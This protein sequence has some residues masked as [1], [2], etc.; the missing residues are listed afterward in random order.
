MPGEQDRERDREARRRGDLL[1]RYSW[2]DVFE[3]PGQMFA[4][5]DDFLA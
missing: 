2:R 3:E 4:E 5:L 1:R